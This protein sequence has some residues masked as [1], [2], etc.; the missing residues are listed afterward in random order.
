MDQRDIYIDIDHALDETLATTQRIHRTTL[1]TVHVGNKI[2]E[3][4]EDQTLQLRRIQKEA[5]DVDSHLNIAFYHLKS[6]QSWWSKKIWRQ[7][8]KPVSPDTKKDVPDHTKVTKVKVTETN[9]TPGVKD[10]NRGGHEIFPGNEKEH[11]IQE[12]LKLIK[13]DVAVLKLQALAFGATIDA[14]NQ[15]I[16]DIQHTVTHIDMDVRRATHTTIKLMS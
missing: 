15:T 8:L 3:T 10:Q 9:T 7:K 14:Q 1:E 5:T 4:L 2:G 12:N 6:M 11:A 13:A 16:A